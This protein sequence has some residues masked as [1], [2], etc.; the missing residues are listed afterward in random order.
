MAPW[1]NECE[2]HDVHC[3]CGDQTLVD[4]TS[5]RTRLQDTLNAS[6]YVMALVMDDPLR[7]VKKGSERACLQ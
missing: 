3:F 5:G 7:Q 2:E 1:T 4:G 6:R